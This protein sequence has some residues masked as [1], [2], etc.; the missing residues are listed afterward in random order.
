MGS[1][2]SKCSIASR[3][4]GENLQKNLRA[5]EKGSL[6]ETVFMG[7]ACGYFVVS[8]RLQGNTVVSELR[9]KS[10]GAWVSALAAPVTTSPGWAPGAGPSGGLVHLQHS[11]LHGLLL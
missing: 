7:C 3:N 4:P 8:C 1:V 10:G 2:F 11:R 9:W 6:G 5:N